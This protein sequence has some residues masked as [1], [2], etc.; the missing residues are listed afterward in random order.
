MKEKKISHTLN[1]SFKNLTGTF[2]TSPAL[3]HL[4]SKNRSAISKQPKNK[5]STF[6]GI[7]YKIMIK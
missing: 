5:A 6:K 7:P 4:K 1:K 3:N 2:L